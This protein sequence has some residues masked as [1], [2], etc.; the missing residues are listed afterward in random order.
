MIY[1]KLE[2]KSMIKNNN[3]ISV[4]LIPHHFP[5]MLIT[6]GKGEISTGNNKKKLSESRKC[7]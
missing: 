1:N 2:K 4:K 3:T 7:I 5:T 6:T